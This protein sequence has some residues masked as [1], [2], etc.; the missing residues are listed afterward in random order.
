MECQEL[1]ARIK[2]LQPQ[3]QTGDVARMCLLVQNIVS[4]LH[5][6]EDESKLD[7]ACREVGLRLQHAGDQHAAMT[8]ELEALAES[9]PRQF[10]PDDIWVL[11]R[12]IKVQNQILQ[13]YASYHAIDV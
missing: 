12:A 1:A 7:A 4:N 2:K 6:L 10:K 3:A 13:L 11:I 8:E 5:D 9:D